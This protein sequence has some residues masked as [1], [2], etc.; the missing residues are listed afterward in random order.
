MSITEIFLNIRKL[1]KEI[2]HTKNE[3]ISEVDRKRDK[4]YMKYY[5]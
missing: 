4:E 5:Y 3:N 1:E 2:M